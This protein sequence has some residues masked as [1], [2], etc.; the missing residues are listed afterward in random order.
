[1][2]LDSFRESLTQAFA[3]IS[4]HKFRSL[5]T[6]LG[7]II[8][9]T[10]VIL[11]SSVVTGLEERFAAM[12][13]RFGTN[14]IF[15]SKFEF[16]GPREPTFEER[17][18]KDLTYEDGLAVAELPS[19]AVATACLGKWPGEQDAAIM[20]Y[21]DRQASRPVLRGG[22][23]AFLEARNMQILAGRYYTEVESRHGMSVAVIGY[24]TAETLFGTTEAVGNE[25]T[26]NGQIFRVVGV[27]EKSA[28]RGMF[29][30]S[31]WEDNCAIIP[32]ATFRRL[33]PRVKDYM[34]VARAK[35][36]QLDRMVDD[37]T[38]L[39]RKR[40]NVPFYKPD[41]FHIS[42]PN[43][44]K[45]GF[46]K[47]TLVLAAIVVPISGMALLIG[48]IGVLNIMLVS[49]TERTKEIGTRRALGARRIDIIMQFLIEAMS[50]TGLGG[51]IGI[52]VGLGVSGV[53]NV[54]IPDLP[55]SVS[56]FWVVTGFAISV[57]IGLVAGLIPAIKAAYLDPAEALRYE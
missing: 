27:L 47:I 24:D 55:S 26:I 2:S 51:C 57:G 12:V 23:P 22:D 41:D 31:N 20:K 19:V 29:P 1:M 18:R 56:A 9:T 17:Q 32:H 46:G 33:Y 16:N 36:G 14:T 30:G 3:T 43:A 39:L 7:V 45:E 48:G 35:D 42:T 10:S 21:R 8:G 4:A 38:R 34:I 15:V 5:L 37:I 13:E 50:L 11:V 52:L 44:E 40:R 54:A 25:F 53:I 28:A 49:V 6:V